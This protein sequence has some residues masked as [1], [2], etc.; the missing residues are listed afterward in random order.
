MET[1]KVESMFDNS[2]PDLEELKRADDSMV[3]AA[4]TGWARVE[5]AA[6][7]RRF[8]A[9]AELVSRR[10]EGGSAECGRWSCD[11][12]DAMAAEIA[13]AQGISHGMASG[14]MYLSVGLRDRLPRVAELF[15]DG[16]IS[17]WLVRMIAWHTYL[18]KD[19]EALRLVDK[20][21]AEDA[22]L[23][24]PMSIHKTVQ[25]I[26]AIV[27]R[28]DPGALRRTRATARSREVVIDS[29][30]QQSGTAAIWG[31]LFATDATALDR[32]LMQ[33]A[34]EVCDD[35]PRTIAQRRADALGA[36]AAGAERLKC[37]CGNANCPADAEGA[38]RSSG[39]VIHVV[40]DASA[41]NA[42]PDQHLSGAPTRQPTATGAPLVRPPAPEPEPPG[43]WVA[44]PPA[45]LI[46]S[47][48]VVPTPLLA[49]LIKR[50]AK[51]QPL[52]HTGGAAPES[53]YRP[54]AAVERFVRCRDLSC[55]F[56]GCD[57][58]AEF[59]DVDHTVPY[60]LGPT[61]P[62]NLKCL[63][64]KHH[65]LKTFW[66][67]TNGW[68]DEQLPDGTVIWTAPTGQRY[69]TRPGSRLLFPSLC[70]PTRELPSA[71]TV[72]RP[73][74]DRGVMMPVRRRTREQDRAHRID[75]ERAL[76]NAHIAERNQPPP[77]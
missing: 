67:G 35:D 34:H 26:E 38:E 51:I 40:A 53:G 43:G 49:E 23:F 22:A 48:G 3:V 16:M 6:S 46:T 58:P 41:V 33:M 31:R 10:V 54:S 4:V 1:P 29:A 2:L 70:L 8:A 19:S 61:H 69:T 44:K 27:D 55:R 11:N 25:A 17:Y 21:I 72:D 74:G 68:R 36:L 64:R 7:A 37:A 76:N 45:A 18:I 14:Q 56:P 39:V 62:S 75:A 65:L 15:A 77:F 13:A 24:G 42:Q 28:H 52:W 60:P 73:P 9:I 20:T 63:C 12:W 59:C 50:G 57:R 30:D 66:G 32:R 5:A 47:G 71:P